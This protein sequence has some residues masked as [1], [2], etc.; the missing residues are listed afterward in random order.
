MNLAAEDDWP[1]VVR[2]LSR[3]RVVWK[4]MPEIYSREGA[5]PRVSGFKKKSVVQAVLLFSAETWVV[6]PRMGRVLGGLQDQVARRLTG[7]ILRHKTDRKWEYT[8]E[9]IAR[10]EAGFKT[11]EE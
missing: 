4:R 7:R 11:M 3:E 10:E 2:N 5:D 8:S 9:E 1:A 6:T